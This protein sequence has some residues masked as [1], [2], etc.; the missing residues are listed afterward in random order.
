VFVPN[1]RLE[2]IRDELARGRP[3]AEIARELGVSPSTIT[4]AARGLGFPDAR[5]RPSNTDWAAV[6]RH[7]DAGH[8]IAEC[9]E[10]FHFTLSAWDKAVARGDL[11]VRPR[12]NGELARG[13]RDRVEDLLAR[14]MTQADI[15]RELG[16]TKSTVAY[17][18]RR[19]GL[20]ADP[21][22]AR[23]IDWKAIQTA[24]DEE[25]LSMARCLAR[26]EIAR[27]TWYR[28]IARGDVA[29]GPSKMPIEEL[30]V[31]GRRTSR[32]HLK[33]RLTREGIKQNRCERCGISEWLGAALSIHIHHKNGDPHDN[34]LE[35]LQMLCPNCHAQ[36]DTYGGRN[37]HRRP[38]PE[39]A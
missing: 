16:V 17:H 20:R 10:R 29:P 19:L 18:A 11:A 3:R 1:E 23:R 33:V 2:W 25:G 31:A 24:I 26:F 14:G 28:A 7:Y 37:G 35:N 34:R 22:F 9:R 12:G 5:P 15:A 8:S 36:T 13:T 30:L 27:D 21:R 4:R 32:R 38:G 39:V 6:Q